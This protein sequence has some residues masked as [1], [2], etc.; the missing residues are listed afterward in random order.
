MSRVSA[1]LE[2]PRPWTGVVAVNS[3]IMTLFLWHLT[4]FVIV[5]VLLYPLGLGTPIE[6]TASWWLQRPVWILAPLIVL[7]PMLF[8]FG[9][10]ERS[11]SLFPVIGVS[12]R[13]S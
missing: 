12:R 5:I 8:V 10:F 2:R 11:G 7:S 13:A 4:A 9:R 3:M 6:P 1:W